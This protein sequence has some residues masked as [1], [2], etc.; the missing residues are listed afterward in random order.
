MYRSGDAIRVLKMNRGMFNLWIQRGVIQPAVPAHG[1]G[2]KAEF[3]V[4]SI[5]AAVITQKLRK[6]RID[7]QL[8]AKIGQLA[9]IVGKDIYFNPETKAHEFKDQPEADIL[10]R[11][12]T[13]RIW[14][15]TEKLLKGEK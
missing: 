4:R 1:C 13:E 14:Q 9:A 12:N 3:D 2:T 7:L 8:A 11:I 10:L 6:L 5:V 15:E